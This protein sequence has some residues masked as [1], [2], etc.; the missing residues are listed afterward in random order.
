M[1]AAPACAGHW[2]AAQESHSD[3]E[4]ACMAGPGP[5]LTVTHNRWRQSGQRL[6]ALGI[7]SCRSQRTP[8]GPWELHK[9]EDC[10]QGMAQ[11]SRPGGHL[12]SSTCLPRAQPTTSHGQIDARQEQLRVTLPHEVP[13]SASWAPHPRLSLPSRGLFPSSVCPGSHPRLL[14]CPEEPHP[15][16]APNI[17]MP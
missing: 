15:R 10:S 1:P 2:L 17:F 3:G 4:A 16:Q 6:G 11:Q 12:A 8:I 13:S 9:D 5:P 14:P 7:H